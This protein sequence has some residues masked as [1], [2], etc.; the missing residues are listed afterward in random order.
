MSSSVLESQNPTQKSNSEVS[1][2]KETSC[3][4]LFTLFLF[5]KYLMCQLEAIC[6]PVVLS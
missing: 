5:D 1:A 3:S 4:N 2:Y 6:G